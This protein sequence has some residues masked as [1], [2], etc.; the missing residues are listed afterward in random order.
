MD[1]SDI[2]LTVFTPTYNRRDSLPKGYEAL[3][4]Q[5][6]KDFIWLIID[7]GSTDDTVSLVREWQSRDNG[8]EIRYCYKE[9]GG[10]H[11]GYNKA[12]ELMDTELCVCIDSDDYM[13][14][15]AVELILDFWEKRGSDEYA[16]IIALDCYENGEVIGGPLPAVESLYMIELATKYKRHGDTKMVLRTELLKQVAPQHSY[17]G[18]KNFNPIYMLLKVGDNYPFLILNENLCFVEYQPGGMSNNIFRQYVNSPNS[19]AALR[20]QNMRLKRTTFSYKMRQH[21]HYVSSCI[22]A[23]RRSVFKDSA[24]RLMTFAAL[25]PG[26]LL[27]FYIKHKIK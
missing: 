22:L 7:D 10:L 20:L 16:G 11:T 14:D 9:N 8:F 4:R 2:R 24:N 13:S 1:S 5:T 17:P 18:E 6:N 3:L 12:I 23:R 21:I 26:V 19:F 27:Y 15:N 25:L